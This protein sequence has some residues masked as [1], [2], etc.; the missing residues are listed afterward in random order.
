MGCEWLT[1]M[2]RDHWLHSNVLE[3]GSPALAQRCLILL[4]RLDEAEL[5]LLQTTIGRA[6]TL[7][8]VVQLYLILNI[9]GE[10]VSW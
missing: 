8:L 4:Q 3:T 10:N 5:E 7:G 9:I 1:D 6:G 2:P